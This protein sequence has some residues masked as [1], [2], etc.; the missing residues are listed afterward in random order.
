M[1][2]NWQHQT[3]RRARVVFEQLQAALQS[4]PDDAAREQFMAQEG[5]PYFA[6]LDKIYGEDYQVARLLDTSDLVV[7]AEGPELSNA[8]PALRA[9]SWLCDITNQQ[10]RNLILAT[11]DLSKITK[12]KAS[13][14]I[15]LRLTGLAPGSL[16]AGFKLLPGHAD[17]LFDPET[18]SAYGDARAAMQ[19]I[20]QIPTFIDDERLLPDLA[21]IM[22]DPAIRDAS[23]MAAY[24][25][26]PSGKLGIHTLGLLVPGTPASE[27]G[28][29]ERVVLR[30]ALHHP[31]IENWKFGRFVGEIRELDIDKTRFHLRDVPDIGSLR[32][33]VPDGW[34]RHQVKSIMAEWIAASGRYL[35]DATG[36]PRLL[37]VEQIDV[38]PRPQQEKIHLDHVP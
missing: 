6:L 36:R 25:M 12:R 17:D 24:H 21:E 5:N 35:M 30:E 28:Q 34:D 18:E 11:M 3:H 8:M 9:T 33:V 16:Y 15:N 26:A 31:L 7:H 22:P 32:C 37:Y 23:L 19:G 4:A 14:A 2:M 13:G 20:A 38:L 29:R 10:L 1:S 27:L